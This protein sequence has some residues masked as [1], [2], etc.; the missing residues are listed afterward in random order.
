MPQRVTAR[1]FSDVGAKPR[2]L[3]CSL[4]NRFMQMVP[5]SFTRYSSRKMTGCR[6]YPLPAPLPTCVW[7]FLLQSIR[8]RYTTQVPFQVLI[9]LPLHHFKMSEKR[10]PNSRRKHGMPVFVSFARS[11]QYMI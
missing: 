5:A 8:Q 4:E 3:K 6:K 7:I 9:V 10:L 2:V 11:N 1:W